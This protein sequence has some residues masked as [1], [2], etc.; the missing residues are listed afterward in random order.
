MKL[1]LPL[2]FL[3][4]FISHSQTATLR[5]LG[6][7]DYYQSAETNVMVF[8]ISDEVLDLRMDLLKKQ[9]DSLGIKTPIQPLND[10]LLKFSDQ[11]KFQVEVENIELFE[12]LVEICYRSNL[13]ID[14][15]YFEMPPHDY[16]EE[17]K[18][19]FLALK[20]AESQARI[21]ANN[22][23]YKIVQILNIDDE[24]KYADPFFDFVDPDS[25]RGRNLIKLITILGR[26]DPPEITKSRELTRYGGYN[27]WVTFEITA[28]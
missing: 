1:F 14:E 23:N 18:Y 26:I 5:V 10:P 27:L 4:S 11:Q 13:R 24:T 3:V 28:N 12:K 16:S 17:D 8:H 6:L 25:Q 20:N 21:I 9:M 7:A 22:L 15:I 2:F 19:A